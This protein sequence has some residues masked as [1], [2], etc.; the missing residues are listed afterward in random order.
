MQAL[1]MSS[2]QN[3]ITNCV[4]STVTW[5]YGEAHKKPTNAWVRPGR[6]HERRCF[7]EKLI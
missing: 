2:E 4:S 3:G 6:T 1:A 5:I 7:S